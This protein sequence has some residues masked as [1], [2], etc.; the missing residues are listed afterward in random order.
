[1]P[2][3]KLKTEPPKSN[4]APVTLTEE[5]E[6]LY[7]VTPDFNPHSQVSQSKDGSETGDS[8]RMEDESSMQSAPDY[9]DQ[10]RRQET[11]RS[12]DGEPYSREE[13]RRSRSRTYDSDSDS[14]TSSDD[15]DAIADREA[16]RQME[17]NSVDFELSVN[18]KRM[19]S[20]KEAAKK[21]SGELRIVDFPSYWYGHDCVYTNTCMHPHTPIQTSVQTL[22]CPWYFTPFYCVDI[23]NTV[24]I[25]FLFV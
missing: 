5:D 7:E 15:S 14:S 1:M 11:E 25:N 21:N 17:E 3:Q 12:I 16:V 23:W 22:S 13:S 9:A 18:E 6:Q 24:S 20:M 10:D 8:H 4:A 19:Q 2:L